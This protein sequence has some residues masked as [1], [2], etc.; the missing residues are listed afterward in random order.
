MTPE[1]LAKF[2]GRSN[3]YAIQ[4]DN[5]SYIPVH[6]PIT[7]LDLKQHLEGSKTLGTYV[8][9]ED[10]LVSYGV[11]DIDG[12]A[13]DL[14]PLRKLGEEVYSLFPEFSRVLEF[15]GRRGFHIWIFTSTPVQPAY[16]RELIKTRFREYGISLT[17]EIFP[18]QDKLTGKGLGN[19]VKLPCGKHKKGGFSE[20]IKEEWKQ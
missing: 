12:E 11:V 13:N 19:L 18:K 14:E 3:P 6:K 17:I 7:L 10:G 4:L 1:Q 20:I 9:R 5:G 16:I 15:S 2:V 8:I